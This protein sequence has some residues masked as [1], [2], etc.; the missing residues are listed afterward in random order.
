VTNPILVQSTDSIIFKCQSL[1]LFPKSVIAVS[2]SNCFQTNGGIENCV[3]KEMQFAMIHR[4]DYLVL[5]SMFEDDQSFTNVCKVFLNGVYI[6]HTFLDSLGYKLHLLSPSFCSLH[7]FNYYNKSVLIRFLIPLSKNCKVFIWIHD[8]SYFC[9]S[10]VLL[11]DDKFCGLL[12]IES[13][14]CN[15]CEKQTSRIPLHEFYNR[16]LKIIDIIVF[17]SLEAK[18]RFFNYFSVC[19]ESNLRFD[20]VPHYRVTS[21]RNMNSSKG[22]YSPPLKISFFGHNV[23]HKGWYKFLDL[24]DM[25]ESTG[26]F[27]FYHIGT[28]H[29]SDDRVKHIPFSELDHVDPV[30]ELDLLCKSH[31]IS[32]AFFWS[33]TLESFGMMLRQ[34]L[35]TQCAVLAR[36]DDPA[37]REFIDDCDKIKFFNEF[38]DLISF[39]KD[40][41]AVNDLLDKAA[42]TVCSLQESEYSFSLLT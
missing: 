15:G 8:L 23:L 11:R 6:G 40:E 14:F 28:A 19:N 37:L 3:R 35:A 22:I 32:L 4:L 41:D 13:Q 25:L 1:K 18:K 7:S 2:S 27:Q 17:P 21:E 5:I 42:R 26:K 10:E 31:N 34:V 30:A 29:H 9:D 24:V 12:N 36:G 16:L 38:D 20:I 33:I 39:V